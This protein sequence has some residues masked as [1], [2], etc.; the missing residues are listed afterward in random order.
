MS[1][2]PLRKLNHLQLKFYTIMKDFERVLDFN[3]K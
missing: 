1:Y 3:S 2:F